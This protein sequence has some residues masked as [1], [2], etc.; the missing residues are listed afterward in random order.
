MPPQGRLTPVIFQPADVVD[1]ATLLHPT[2][3]Q[4]RPHRPDC[5]V[6]SQFP[7]RRSVIECN[8]EN[9]HFSK[10]NYCFS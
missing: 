1:G 5:E 4:D 6:I 7:S 2:I 3:E 9:I 8:V 10:D